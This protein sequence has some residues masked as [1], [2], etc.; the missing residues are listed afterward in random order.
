MTRKS[1][2]ASR[3]FD[4]G[5]LLNRRGMHRRLVK[6]VPG[7]LLRD[8]VAMQPLGQLLFVDILAVVVGNQDVWIGR[9]LRI[10]LVKRLD[11][12]AVGRDPVDSWSNAGNNV[13]SSIS[14]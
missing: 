13:V 6:I 12:E 4:R 11:R 9:R 5:Y 14:T 3:V 2:A 10:T 8:R 1:L 7:I